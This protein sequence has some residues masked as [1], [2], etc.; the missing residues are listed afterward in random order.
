MEK[1]QHTIKINPAKVT[2]SL[3]VVSLVIIIL[4][5]MG[6]RDFRVGSPVT[7]FFLEMYKTEFYVNNGE[8]VA[9]YWNMLLLIIMTGLAFTIAIVKYAQKDK[10]KYEWWILTAIFLYF[11]T[12]ELSTLHQKFIKLFINMPTMADAGHFKWLYVLATVIVI[13]LLVFLTRFY[14]HLDHKNKILFPI[15]LILYFLGEYRGE[16]FGGVYAQLHNAK[17]SLFMITTHIEE[18]V[19]LTGIIIMIYILLTYFTS[20]ISELQFIEQKSDK[21]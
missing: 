1:P 15:S 16:Y 19:E 20:H 10:H 13:L 17:N 3:F 6:Q 5:F 8:N 11:A 9:T 7:K 4:S 2:I 14:I 21:E 18:F 12:D